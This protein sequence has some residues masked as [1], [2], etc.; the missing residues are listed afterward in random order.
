MVSAEDH[1]CRN[2][3]FWYIWNKMYPFIKDLYLSK[4]I[5]RYQSVIINYLLAWSWWSEGIESWHSLRVADIDSYS[6]VSNELGHIPAVLYSISKVL[7]TIGSKYK[8]EGV[9]W[10]YEI[11]SKNDAIALDDLESNT[12]FYVEC[13]MRKFILENRENI[14][15]TDRLKLKITNIL[16]FIIQRGSMRGYQ[17]RESIL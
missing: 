5:Y 9:E 2:E 1:L 8:R 17:L 7:C 12:L 11:V 13:F 16:S 6:M 10:L 15:R 3:Q 4:G 14:K